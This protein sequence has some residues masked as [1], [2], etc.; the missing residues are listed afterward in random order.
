MTQIY[1][2]KFQCKQKEIESLDEIIQEYTD[3]I[4]YN[5]L[6]E[7][8]EENE[9]DDWEY[10]IYFEDINIRNDA[11]KA[12][13]YLN[14]ITNLKEG[15]ID[16]TDWVS[17]VQKDFTPIVI[18]D[19]V[20]TSEYYKDNIE[21]FVE[22]KSKINNVIIIDP[23]QAFGTG[24]HETTKLCIE[25]LINIKNDQLPMIKNFA[26]IGTG[27]GILSI[28]ARKLW[29]TDFFSYAC[30][31]DPIAI[32]VAD[33]NFELNGVTIDRS[34]VIDATKNVMDLEDGSMD[35]IVANILPGPLKELMP[36]FEAKLKQGGLVMISGFLERHFDD[37]LFTYSFQDETIDD[38]FPFSLVIDFVFEGWHACLFKKIS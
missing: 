34:E 28:V 8:I 22:D 3:Y 37:I 16:Q 30:D 31:I 27:S 11:F 9:E 25:L 26:D 24:A 5:K 6:T 14:K 20:I 1:T 10:E 33:N 35:L 29:G 23:S 38:E 12:L 7:G 15:V 4:S 32:D 19:L 13:K 21:D 18:Q 17:K 2:I 36:V